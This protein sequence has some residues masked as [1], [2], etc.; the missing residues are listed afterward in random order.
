MRKEKVDNN[1][2]TLTRLISSKFVL[3]KDMGNDSYK[4]IF[5]KTNYGMRHDYYYP[6][7]GT[8]LVY[9]LVPIISTKR[10]IKYK[11][12]EEILRTKNTLYIKSNGRRKNEQR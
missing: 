1:H 4:D 7:V 5:T 2:T 12:A 3:V 8:V 9:N 10:R 11:D 6:V